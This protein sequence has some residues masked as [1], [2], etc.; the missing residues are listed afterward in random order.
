MLEGSEET[1]V[2]GRTFFCGEVIFVCFPKK[3]KEGQSFPRKSKNGGIF[4]SICLGGLF[5]TW[6]RSSKAFSLWFEKENNTG[7]FRS[8]GQLD[9]LSL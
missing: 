8:G 2:W 4:A 1:I 6:G 7:L 5:R 3:P 9:G